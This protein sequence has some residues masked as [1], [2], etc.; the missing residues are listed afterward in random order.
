LSKI[1]SY[2]IFSAL[3]SRRINKSFDCMKNSNHL[4][5]SSTENSC[6]FRES[7][8]NKLYFEEKVRQLK[9]EYLEGRNGS[10]NNRSKSPGNSLGRICMTEF[11]PKLSASKAYPRTTSNDYVLKNK[12]FDD[13]NNSVDT[14]NTE[15][16]FSATEA[17]NQGAPTLRTQPTYSKIFIPV[18]ISRYKFSIL[19]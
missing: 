12:D 3:P 13:V 2:L 5:A 1:S 4:N 7:R 9:Q 10:F 16:M 8:D 15:L 19:L 14:F 17:L 6:F 11:S 18:N